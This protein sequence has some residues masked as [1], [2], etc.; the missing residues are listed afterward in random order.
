MPISIEI[1]EQSNKYFDFFNNMYNLIKKAYNKYTNQNKNIL[2]N[3]LL[4]LEELENDY[5]KTKNI[6]LLNKEIICEDLSQ[7]EKKTQYQIDILLNEYNSIINQI[8]LFDIQK[9]N[10][11]DKL[12]HLNNKI[13]K[14]TLQL[15]KINVFQ[16][17]LYKELD[18]IEKSQQLIYNNNN[19]SNI[20]V[21]NLLE[22]NKFNLDL[23][24]KIYLQKKNHILQDIKL[25]KIQK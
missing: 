12:L 18:S 24:E 15:N 11:S 6:F 2:N 19:D 4:N 16:E 8:K 21:N 25:L 3:L 13:K 5:L 1:I 9:N 17:S 20:F 10:I 23:L 14:Y 7:R 22:T